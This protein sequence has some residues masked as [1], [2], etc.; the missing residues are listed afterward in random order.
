MQIIDI[1]NSTFD[2]SLVLESPLF[3]ANLD[4]THHYI[5]QEGRDKAYLLKMLQD[6]SKKR[7]EKIVRPNNTDRLLSPAVSGTIQPSPGMYF[8]SNAFI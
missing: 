2:P 5:L 4:Q 3:W 6:A 7:K 1:Q 8:L